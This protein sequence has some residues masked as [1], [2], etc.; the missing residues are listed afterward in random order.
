[1]KTNNNFEVALVGNPN[2]GKTSIF[3]NLTKSHQHTG[4]WS[5][6]TVGCCTGEYKY[7][8]AKVR[9][10]DLP[11]M[12]S[13]NANSEEEKLSRDYILNANYDALIIVVDATNLKRN[14]ALV[15]QILYYVQKVILCINMIDEAKKK[16]YEID[17]DELTLQLGIPV[18]T[19][20]AVKNKGIENLKLTVDNLC[21][22][23][24]LTYKVKS[25]YI[26]CDAEHL[27]KLSFSKSSEIYNLCVKK[28]NEITH[29]NKLDAI[30][31]SKLFGIP[32]MI[33]ILLILLWITIFGA[34]FLSEA[35]GMLLL[36]IKH[37]LI[38]LLKY[39]NVS[40]LIQGILIDGVYTTL[41]WV[42]SVMLPPM[43]IFFPLFA[44]LEDSG[45]LPRI[46]FNLDSIFSKAGTCGK[47]SLTMAMGL[48]CSCCGVTGCRI[49]ESVSQRKIGITTNSLTPCNGKLP[50]LI[51]ISTIFFATTG[52]YFLD[53]LSVVASL[54]IVLLISLFVTLAVSKL[55]SITIYK[56]SES[57]FLLELPSYKKPQIAKSIYYSLKHKAV[58]VLLR[59]IVVSIPVGALIWCLANIY[60]NDISVIDYCAGFLNPISYLLGLDGEILL[61]FILGWPANEIVIPII[62]MTYLSAATLQD[63]VS[64]Q[65]LGNILISNGWTIKTGLCFLFMSL[66]HAPCSTTTITIYKE[67][68][69]LKTTLLAILIPTVIGIIGCLLINLVCNIII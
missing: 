20:S 4:N 36:Y 59:A 17:I 35:L 61:A 8:N 1:M 65:E 68:K 57:I 37:D 64:I 26:D 32:I 51:A 12:Y 2:V 28:N 15:L 49:I 10:V 16:G 7:N 54:A 39:I 11:G 27:Q 58:S 14:L 46:A 62:L 22:N 5:G 42:I 55:L 66:F 3:N 23:K 30:I 56:N 40:N 63:Y 21:T 31:N 60:I 9:L 6:K 69:S 48:G 45:L 38:Y 50:G 53:N 19:T 34:N 18:I 33:A 25:L 24:I 41:S 67:T 52:N 47:Q 44:L 29:H 43:T 13:M